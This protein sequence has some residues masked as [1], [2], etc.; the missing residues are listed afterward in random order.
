MKIGRW[1]LIDATAVWTQP[2]A[3]QG[4]VTAIE[5]VVNTCRQS[6]GGKCVE[7]IEE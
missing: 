3:E 2:S 6:M 1:S 7:D 5:E 4:A